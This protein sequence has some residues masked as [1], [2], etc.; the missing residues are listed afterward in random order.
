MSASPAAEA[1]TMGI[2]AWL[3]LAH[4]KPN[5]PCSLYYP[6]CAPNPLH[7]MTTKEGIE[8]I[9]YYLNKSVTEVQI[10]SEQHNR[11]P[12]LYIQ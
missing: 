2:L 1:F 4:T 8:I 7:N 11:Y 6:S 3:S 9:H 10:V 12:Y 5:M